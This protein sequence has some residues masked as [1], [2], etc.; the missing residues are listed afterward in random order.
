M[1]PFFSSME[2]INHDESE[3]RKR[4][5]PMIGVEKKYA[6]PRTYYLCEIP[7]RLGRRTKHSL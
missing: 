4:D 1:N 6:T 5:E 3:E 7:H 2:R